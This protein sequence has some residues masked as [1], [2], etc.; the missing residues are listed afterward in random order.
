MSE[1]KVKVCNA[2][3]II[4]ASRILFG[5]ALLFFPALSTA[6]YVLYILAGVS[7]MLDGFVA[8]RI[9]CVTQFGSNLDTIA[10]FVLVCVCLIKFVPI[11][12]LPS[13]IIIWIA[14][15]ALVKVISFLMCFVSVHSVLNKVTGLLMYLLPFALGLGLS[16]Y[17]VPAI[18]A[19]ATIAAANECYTVLKMKKNR[20]N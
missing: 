7:D 8:R 20:Y 16:T 13:W 3:N 6:F 9:G 18:C 1:S 15:I 17:V 5:L 2:A 12:S 19:V 11:L 4:T 14:L 10:D